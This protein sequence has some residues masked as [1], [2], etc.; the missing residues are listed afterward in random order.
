MI[1]RAATLEDAPMIAALE[2]ALFGSTAWP[3]A[4]VRDELCAPYRTYLVL[5]H[6]GRIAGYGGMLVVGTDADIQTIAIVPEQRGQ[7]TGRTL[8]MKLLE[9]AVER[10]ASQVFLEVR[11]DNPVAIRLYES[12][13]FETIGVREQYY[14]PEGIDALIMRLTLPTEPFTKGNDAQ[15]AA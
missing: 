5:E 1:W 4:V 3:E 8:L 10:G 7:G 14:Q 13:G 15:H 6:E 11:R 12:V 9:A 2:S